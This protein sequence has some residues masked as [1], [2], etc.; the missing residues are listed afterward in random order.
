MAEKQGDFESQNESAKSAIIG[1]IV[2]LVRKAG[3]D[4]EGWRYV[5][6][7]VRQAC[8]LRPAKKGRKLPKVLNAD[9]FRKC[10]AE[11]DK[12]HR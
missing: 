5:S 3:L 7:Q 2:R 10:Y 8:E 12:A 11:V 6:K 1:Q 4:Y 9:D